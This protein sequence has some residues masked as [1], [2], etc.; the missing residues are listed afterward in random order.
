MFYYYQHEGSA[1]VV[2]VRGSGEAWSEKMMIGRLEGKGLGL[3]VSS[4]GSSDILLGTGKGVM[5]SFSM[6]LVRLRNS[7]KSSCLSQLR[8]NFFSMPSRTQVLLVLCEGS[9]V[10]IC[11]G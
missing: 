6:L 5:E 8:S 9:Q 11:E 2:G 3:E 4:K 10:C 7:C 1:W